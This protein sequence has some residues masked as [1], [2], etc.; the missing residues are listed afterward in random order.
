MRFLISSLLAA[1]L[2]TPAMAEPLPEKWQSRREAMNQLGDKTCA[3]DEVAYET[4]RDGLK[5]GDPVAM[6][7]LR[8]VYDNCE[9][10]ETDE[11]MA[12]ASVSY[13][14]TA[15]EM[16][17]PVSQSNLGFCQIRGDCDGIAM[18]QETGL[19]FVHAAIAGGYGEAAYHLGMRLT[20]D[21]YLEPNLELAK[22]LLN[23]AK[24]EGVESSKTDQLDAAWNKA[25]NGQSLSTKALDLPVEKQRILFIQVGYQALLEHYY[26]S[27]YSDSMS[28]KEWLESQSPETLKALNAD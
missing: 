25:M 3:G 1:L 8:W 4:L 23:I 24:L 5:N 7:E 21:R 17:Y 6:H 19:Y 12:L 27:L 9:T 18:D 2:I 28:M 14:V 26:E 22:L 16:G 20:E 13:L 11:W 15:A 10:G